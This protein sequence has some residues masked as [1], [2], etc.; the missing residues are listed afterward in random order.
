MTIQAFKL[1]PLAL[2]MLMP[3][4]AEEPGYYSPP[5]GACSR[6]SRPVTALKVPVPNKKFSFPDELL[7]RLRRSI[8]AFDKEIGELRDINDAID[9]I[10]NPY[11]SSDLGAFLKVHNEAFEERKKADLKPF[12]KELILWVSPGENSP[13]ETDKPDDI[14]GLSDICRLSTELPKLKTP[15]AGQT[16]LSEE[17]RAVVAKLDKDIRDFYA[18]QLKQR[19]TVE[20]MMKLE[21]GSRCQDAVL[22]YRR[23]QNGQYRGFWAHRQG[24][25]ARI[26][27]SSL[28][29]EAF[30]A[31]EK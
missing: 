19:Q 11:C 9:D 8:I 21:N 26:A 4:Q 29:W 23:L 16:G 12:A 25:L 28:R 3:A 30:P 14:W 17:N 18:L 6:L 1:L 31:S 24:E 5:D 27:E 13:K 20:R 15:G 22:A 10:S 7:P 2:F